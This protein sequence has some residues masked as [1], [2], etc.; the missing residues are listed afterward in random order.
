MSEARRPT[1]R[2]ALWAVTLPLTLLLVACFSGATGATSEI[3]QED[4]DPDRILTYEQNTLYMYGDDSG[5][6]WT[7][8]STWNHAEPNDGQ[9]T[10]SFSEGNGFG[11]SGGGMREFTFDGTDAAENV[12][13]ISEE[14][15]IEGTLTL[16][17]FCQGSC[18]KEVTLTLRMGKPGS[19]ADISS[20]TLNGPDEVDGDIYTFSFQGHRIDELDGG[21]VFGLRLSFQKPSGPLDSYSLY[22]GRDNFEMT[23]PVLPP[24]EEEVPGLELQEGEEYISPYAVGTAGFAEESA[25]SS[26]LVGPIMMALITVGVLFL[27]MYLLPPI[28]IFKVLTF[29][30]VGLGMLSSLTII[31]IVSGPVALSTS[32]DLDAPDVWTIDEIASL[33]EREGTFLGELTAGTEFTVFIEYDKVYMAK[34]E[35]TMHYGFGFEPY[36][37]EL[38]DIQETSARGREYVQLFFSMTDFDPTPGSAVIIN[39]KLINASDG[40]GG[41]KVV[42]QWAVPGEGNNQFWVKDETFGGR[43]VI[44]EVDAQGNTVIEVL[45]VDY[46]WQYYPMSGLLIGAILSGIGIWQWRRANIGSR[47]VAEDDY[48]FDDDDY[49]DDDFDDDDFDFDDDDL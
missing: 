44:P 30:F 34:N 23:I 16:A 14:N 24:Y 46:D 25:A 13:A 22:L 47:R 5:Q 41:N 35:G 49:E 26:G 11:S 48:D 39:V 10:S 37:E 3:M 45:G 33:Q 31:P 19:L 38:G 21:E 12:T 1:S 42:P 29:I 18:S 6:E 9:S 36:A 32:V 20:V 8:W 28:G 15:A 40:E 17:I 4:A 7:Q 2:T 27:I 43:W